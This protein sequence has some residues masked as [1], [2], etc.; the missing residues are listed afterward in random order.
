MADKT[1][2]PVHVLI[3]DGA[4]NCRAFKGVS[5]LVNAT[6]NKYEQWGGVRINH[7]DEALPYLGI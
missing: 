5:L 4:H 1:D 3:D 6:H 7:L 2:A